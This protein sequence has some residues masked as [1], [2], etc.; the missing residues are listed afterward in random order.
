MH[1]RDG[2]RTE[3]KPKQC[4]YRFLSAQ[5]I[6]TLTTFIFKPVISCSLIQYKHTSFES[7]CI[8]ANTAF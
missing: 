1:I 6:H 7:F 2:N 5:Q 3:L 8:L 4:I